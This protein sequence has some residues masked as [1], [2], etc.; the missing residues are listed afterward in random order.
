MSGFSESNISTLRIL[1]LVLGL[2]YFWEK[3]EDVANEVFRDVSI[4]N[5]QGVISIALDDDKIW[6]NMTK[7]SENHGGVL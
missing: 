3:A 1:L 7:L 5:R 4:T 6:V 2:K